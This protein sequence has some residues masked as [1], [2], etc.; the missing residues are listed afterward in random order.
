MPQTESVRKPLL[1]SLSLVIAIFLTALWVNN[2]VLLGYNLQLT[3][4]LVVTYFI[5]RLFLGKAN[6]LSNTN[7]IFD[8]VIF[9]VILLLVIYTTG[10]LNSSLFFLIYLLLFAVALL[11]EPITTLTLTLAIIIFFANCLTSTHSVLQLL[12]L[13]FISPLAIYFG[14]LYLRLLQAKEKIKILKKSEK[15]LS[16]ETGKLEGNISLQETDSLLWLTLNLKNNLLRI[17]HLSAD[18]LAD[19]G[20]LT[21]MQKDNLQSIHESAKELLKSGEKLKEKIDRETD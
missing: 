19:I 21:L 6:S 11:F 9:T 7:L 8:S 5:F 12:S 16:V 13:L 18:L 14:K 17:V 4:I 1:N 20:H 3:G 15:S 2:P 10:G